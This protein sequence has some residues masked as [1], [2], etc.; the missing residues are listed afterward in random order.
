MQLGVGDDACGFEVLGLGLPG[1]QVGEAHED[2]DRFLPLLGLVQKIEHID[3][4]IASVGLD[5]QRFQVRGDGLLRIGQLVL[6]DPN[7]FFVEAQ[8]LFGV[9]RV[10]KQRTLLPDNRLPVLGLGVDLGQSFESRAMAGIDLER[11]LEHVYRL[12]AL[13][14]LHL[15]RA[16]AVEYLHDLRVGLRFTVLYHHGLVQLESVVPLLAAVEQIGAVDQR[17]QV[18]R[19][20]LVGLT[21]ALERFVLLTELVCRTGQSVIDSVQLFVG[22]TIR[23]ARQHLQHRNEWSPFFVAVVDLR[24]RRTSFH[25]LGIELERPRKQ[26]LGLLLVAEIDLVKLASFEE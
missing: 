11:L 18:R 25:M 24:Q 20:Q 7:D 23:L 8:L 12:R 6:V 2:L 10:A 19:I 5:L 17:W 26:V 3:K 4:Q 21:V 22:A 9:R 13:A 15:D 16:D 1:L 14:H